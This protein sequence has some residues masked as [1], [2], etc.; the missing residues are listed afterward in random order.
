MACISYGLDFLWTF[1]SLDFLGISC[2]WIPCGFLMAWIFQVLGFLWISPARISY[3]AR[4]PMALISK[5]LG[6]SWEKIPTRRRNMQHAHTYTRARTHTR[7]CKHTHTHTHTHTQTH[8]HTNTHTQTHARARTHARTHAYTGI[9]T[10]KIRPS[11]ARLEALF[12]EVYL[13][14]SI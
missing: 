9:H 8:T 6:F 12:E 14:I 3:G 2:G 11:N 1:Y 10:K 13:L 5:G 7:T 4:F